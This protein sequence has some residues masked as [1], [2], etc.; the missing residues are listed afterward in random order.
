M[1]RKALSA[2]HTWQNQFGMAKPPLLYSVN[3]KLAMQFEGNS[4]CCSVSAEPIGRSHCTAEGGKRCLSMQ[5]GTRVRTPN[6]NCP[7]RVERHTQR[8]W[9]THVPALMKAIR[10]IHQHGVWH[11]QIN[12]CNNRSILKMHVSCRT[13][14]EKHLTTKVWFQHMASCVRKSASTTHLMKIHIWC[15]PLWP[16]ASATFARLAIWPLAAKQRGL[17]KVNRRSTVF[18]CLDWISKGRLAMSSHAH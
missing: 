3:T 10:P 7:A 18:L 11:G 6:P 8:C 15:E 14:L 5:L 2:W 13:S 4:L 16:C 1:D 17:K 9:K 12:W